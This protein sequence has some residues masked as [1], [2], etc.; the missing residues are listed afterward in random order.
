MS[1][2]FLEERHT[3]APPYRRVAVSSIVKLSPY[4]PQDVLLTWC[5]EHEIKIRYWDTDWAAVKSIWVIED[6]AQRLIFWLHW[7]ELNKQ[8]VDRL[9]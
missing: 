7:S 2:A 1:E 4:I 8:Y 9:K 3:C 6:S 5:E